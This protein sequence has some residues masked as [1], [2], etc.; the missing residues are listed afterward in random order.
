MVVMEEPRETEG[1]WCYGPPER[2]ERRKDSERHDVLKS[3]MM[4]EISLPY[5]YNLAR[6]AHIL[7]AKSHELGSYADLPDQGGGNRTRMLGTELQGLHLGRN[8]KRQHIK[9][10]NN[11]LLSGLQRGAL[12]GMTPEEEY[13]D[14][15]QL[16][17]R[18][19]LR[20]KLRSFS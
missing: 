1:S 5:P 10:H 19:P 16:A 9:S 2:E 8:Q 6:L 17:T 3:R 20:P 15:A 11:I 13:K 12:L 4:Q 18:E 7:P 14:G